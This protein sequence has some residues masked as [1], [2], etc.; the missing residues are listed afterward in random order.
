MSNLNEIGEG[1]GSIQSLPPPDLQPAG[2]SSHGRD[3]SRRLISGIAT[4]LVSRGAAAVAPLILIPITLAYLGSEVYGLWMATAAIAS[5]ALWAD[6]GLGNGLLTKLAPCHANGDWDAARRYV[7]TAYAV[8]IATAA[9]LL[10]LL[11]ALS[12]VVPWASIFN[13]TDPSLVPLAKQIALVCLS[14]LL[15]NI[16]LS[17]VQRVQYAHQQVA[18]SNLWQAAG[19][20][21]SVA[22]AWAA[23]HAKASPTVVVSAAVAGPL[24]VNVANSA[25]VYLRE[26]RLLAPRPGSVDRRFA[27]A[28]IQLGSQFFILSIVTSIALNADNLII[29]HTLGL[30]AVTGYAVPAKLFTAL[31]LI[32]TLVNLPLWPANGEALAHRDLEWV[33]RTTRRMTLVSG[34]AI[35]LP[36]ALLIIGGNALISVW[37]GGILHVPSLLLVSLA[38]WWLSLA[39]ASP[40][41]MVQNAAGLVRP[42]LVGWAVFLIVSVPLKWVAARE[43]GIAGVPL[44]GALI[45]L[46][47]LWPAAVVGFRH[48]LSNTSSAMTEGSR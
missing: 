16:P 44:V 4:S 34:T 13:V 5:M 17:L 25:F 37:V 39:T 12:G 48:A 9:S 27:R 47:C 42:Q 26:G 18:Q 19:S 3:R 11:W 45:Y 33:R 22:L 28:L 32:V 40:R 15:I 35:L 8:L 29:A 31:G 14:A 6:F 36:S 41:F 7:S 38:V 20:F 21:V 2:A 23:V 46:L 1:L 43:F 24:L 30:A 10:G